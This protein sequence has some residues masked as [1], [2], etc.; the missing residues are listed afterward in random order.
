MSQLSHP[1][2]RAAKAPLVENISVTL[3]ESLFLT[4]GASP[5]PPYLLFPHVTTEP[6]DLRAAKAKGVEN[7]AV[8][9]EES[10]FLTDLEPLLESLSTHVTDESPPYSLC[11][12]VT[13]EP[14]DFKA[15]KAEC[16]A[17]IAVTSEEI[18]DLTADESPPCSLSPK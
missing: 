5:A 9:S 11:P 4:E 2:L 16:V 3:E 8:T 17:N 15:A 18:L 10:L 1:D 12:H 6:S 14:S 13:T 7:I